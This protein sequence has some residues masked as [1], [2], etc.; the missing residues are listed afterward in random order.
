MHSALHTQEE[1]QEAY[2]W[3]EAC[4]KTSSKFPPRNNNHPPEINIEDLPRHLLV[5]HKCIEFTRNARP[6]DKQ[7]APPHPISQKASL[8][9]PCRRSMAKLIVNSKDKI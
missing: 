4:G 7:A 5:M 9:P 1:I 2:D 8:A 6:A 3:R